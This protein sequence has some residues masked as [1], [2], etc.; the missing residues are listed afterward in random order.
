MDYNEISDLYKFYVTIEK[1]SR[2]LK[3]LLFNKHSLKEIECSKIKYNEWKKYTLNEFDKIEDKEYL[4]IWLREKQSLAQHYRDIVI[5]IISVMITV[6]IIEYAKYCA[7]HFTKLIIKNIAIAF[8]MLLVLFV[9]LHL[10]SLRLIRKILF[11]QCCLDLL[12]ND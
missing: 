12:N 2:G 1:E 11:Y 8:L 5:T 6:I 10:V 7:K 3:Q 9:F 4:K